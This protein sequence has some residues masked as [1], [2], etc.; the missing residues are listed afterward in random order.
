MNLQ[1]IAFT[2]NRGQWD[3]QVRFRANAGEF[4][5]ATHHLNSRLTAIAQIR[6][7]SKW[8]WYFKRAFPLSLRLGL[9]Q[10]AE[11]IVL[12]LPEDFTLI[13]L[14][15]VCN[16]VDSAN[17]LNYEAVIN[18][19]SDDRIQQHLKSELAEAA[20][21]IGMISL[22]LK[23]IDES[24]SDSGILYGCIRV[25][26]DHGFLGLARQLAQRIEDNDERIKLLCKLAVLECR[27]SVP[28]DTK[29]GDE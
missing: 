7:D 20:V 8:D 2:E 26:I 15:G 25:S 23:L 27:A 24:G 28:S 5:K 12:N 9:D 29:L 21:R 14:L 18:K 13:D 6:D 4:E 1:P 17:W 19:L 16:D 22:A 3:A 10:V 11:S